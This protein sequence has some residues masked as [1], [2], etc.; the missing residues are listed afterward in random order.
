MF[1]K[2]SMRHYKLNLALK[3]YI[4]CVFSV[5]LLL[6]CTKKQN[7]EAP[8][9]G[10]DYF[11]GTK[12]SYIVYDVDS[13]AYTALPVDTIHAKFLIKEM[14]DSVFAD[15]QGRP[16]LKIVRYKKTYS[17]TIPYSQMSWEIQDVWAANKTVST[18]EVVEE[19]T[20]FIK[21]IFPVKSGKTWNGN[22]QNTIGEWNYKYENVDEALTINNLSFDKTLVVNQ[23]YYPTLISYQRYTEKYAKGVGMIYREITDVKS[24]T[25]TMAPILSR[26]EEGI[27]YKMNV[28]DYYIA[29]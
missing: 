2:I 27:V 25:I 4:V 23:K 3:T 20:R 28:I 15:N 1:T 18:A 29:P 11:P 5:F 21:L 13:T 8:D 6:A 10:S 24:N 26:I 14:I 7:E 17:P 16:T 19:N 22:A 12:G 9:I